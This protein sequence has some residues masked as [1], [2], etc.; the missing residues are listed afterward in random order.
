[1][2]FTLHVS[3][4]FA[5]QGI[6]TQASNGLHMTPRPSRFRPMTDGPPLAFSPNY[7]TLSNYLFVLFIITVPADPFV[8]CWAS[9]GPTYGYRAAADP[10]F[11]RPR[12]ARTLL[13]WPSCYYAFIRWLLGS[14]CSSGALSGVDLCVALSRWLFVA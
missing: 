5:N 3:Q 10:L 8:D 14:F 4:T 6:V 11:H 7:R 9:A 12:L 2:P 1:M 13:R